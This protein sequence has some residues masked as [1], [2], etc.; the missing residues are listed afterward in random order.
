MPGEEGGDA[1]DGISLYDIMVM[2]LLGMMLV[3]I[4]LGLF[5]ACRQGMKH[6][7]R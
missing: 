6:S 7:F 1:E 2:S 5:F 4:F 3:A